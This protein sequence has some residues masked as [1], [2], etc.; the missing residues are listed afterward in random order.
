MLLILVVK[1]RHGITQTRFQ[2]NSV[3]LR[4]KRQSGNWS[5][6]WHL[7]TRCRKDLEVLQDSGEEYKC[8]TLG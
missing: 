2:L 1:L 7:L 6:T 5:F 3:E 8:A 4:G